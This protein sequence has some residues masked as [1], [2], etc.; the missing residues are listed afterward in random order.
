[1]LLR[2]RPFFFAKIRA[3]ADRVPH[4]SIVARSPSARSVA[5]EIGRTP[6]GAVR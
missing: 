2:C 4:P 5:I 1:M 3:L 6:D